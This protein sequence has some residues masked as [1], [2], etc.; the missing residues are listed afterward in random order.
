MLNDVVHFDPEHPIPARRQP[1]VSIRSIM[2][3]RVPLDARRAF[4]PKPLTV[5]IQYLGVQLSA[6]E[7]VIYRHRLDGLDDKWQDAGG[8][9]EAVYTR[10]GP[11]TYTFRVMASTGDGQRTKPVSSI[12]F[13]I[14]PTFYQTTWFI[15]VC[16]LATLALAWVLFTLRVRSVARVMSARAEER[17]EERVRIARELHDT[18][19]GDLAGVAMQLKAG[20]RRVAPLGIADG[21]VVELLS[22]LSAQVQRSLVAARKSVTSMRSQSPNEMSPLHEQ[23]LGAAQHTFADTGVAA[24]VEHAGSP[25]P[26]PPTVASEILGIAT[27]AMT[28]ARNH[29]DCRTVTIVCGYSRRE[30]QVRVR[31]DG[32]GFDPSQETPAGHWGLVG[33]R[34]RAALVRGSF[35]IESMSGEGT[36]V[37]LELPVT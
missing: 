28:N 15:V 19:L 13:T 29:A 16:V 23:L 11:G 14:L 32:R 35:H 22:G 37:F 36:T 1:I 4:R 9:T 2:A 5:A 18:L 27:E 7:R 20:A 8:R 12:A 3:D 26:Y 30:L 33:M 6:P 24:R 34:E 31:D 17:A 25:R 21:A 10:L